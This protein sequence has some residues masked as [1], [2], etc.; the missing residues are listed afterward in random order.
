MNDN[1]VPVPLERLK[2][3]FGNEIELVAEDGRPEV[4]EIKAEFQLGP[5]VYASL[6]SAAMAKEQE[7]ELFRVILSD[8]GEPQLETIEDDEEWELAAEAY[9]DLLFAGDEM[10]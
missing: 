2:E 3:T 5:H 1:L 6:Q 8:S 9:D 10:P 7:V 4:Y